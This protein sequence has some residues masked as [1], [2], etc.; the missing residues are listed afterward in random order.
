MVAD[1]NIAQ[2]DAGKVAG[3]L[4]FYG[5]FINLILESSLGI[6][7]D[8]IGRKML[9]VFGLILSGVSMIM[10]TEFSSVY[11]SLL[12]IYFCYTGGSVPAYTAPIMNDYID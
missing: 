8:V 2:S 9:I 1:Y 10:M 12:I 5:S 7:I 11:P 3:K 6:L 4:G